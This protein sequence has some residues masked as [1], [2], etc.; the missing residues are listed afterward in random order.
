MG[1]TKAQREAKKQLEETSVIKKDPTAAPPLK[2]KLRNQL[3]KDMDVVVKSGFNGVLFHKNDKTGYC[4]EFPHIGSE[5]ELTIEDLK[6]TKNSHP[7]Y[8]KK[9]WL[10]IEDQN[11][12]YDLGL[13]KYFKYVLSEDKINALFSNKC[14]I[15][16]FK[17][18]ISDMNDGQRKSIL[19][20]ASDGIENKKLDSM[21]KIEFL[22]KEFD[23]DLIER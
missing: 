22:E 5:Q 18:E 23:V 16:K 11:V 10:V 2:K 12:V 19:Y 15:E 13:E 6:L 1:Y 21:Q 7:N 20:A 8:F 9:G 14:S 3:P 4:V 17:K